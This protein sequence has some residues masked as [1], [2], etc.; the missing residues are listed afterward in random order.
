MPEFDKLYLELYTAMNEAIACIIR[1][2][3]PDA[4]EKLVSAQTSTVGQIIDRL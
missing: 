1:E 3:Y 2:E 4:I